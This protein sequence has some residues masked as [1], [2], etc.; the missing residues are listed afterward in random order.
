MW[1]DNKA[2]YLFVFRIVYT[3]EKGSTFD[4]DCAHKYITLP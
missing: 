3:G 1:L 4:E 2:D